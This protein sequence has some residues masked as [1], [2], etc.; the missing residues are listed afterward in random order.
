MQIIEVAKSV[1]NSK[2]RLGVIKLK[3]IR[4]FA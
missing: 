1:S 2:G 4:K 3:L